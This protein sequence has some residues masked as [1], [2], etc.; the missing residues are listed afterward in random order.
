MSKTR[1]IGARVSGDGAQIGGLTGLAMALGAIL[2]VGSAVGVIVSGVVL[3]QQIQGITYTN[4]SWVVQNTTLPPVT[5]GTEH[6]AS[7]SNLNG[8][9]VIRTFLVERFPTY[10]KLTLS[11]SGFIV[12]TDNSFPMTVNFT[13]AIEPPFTFPRPSGSSDS[14]SQIIFGIAPPVTDSPQPTTA[15]KVIGIYGG[16]NIE[17]I[18]PAGTNNAVVFNAQALFTWAL[19]SSGNPINGI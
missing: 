4:Y 2:V 13:N 9:I 3:S 1:R 17:L 8:L 6:I 15:I 19:D 11:L 5:F 16:R 18:M 12:S 7:S 14:A 10:T